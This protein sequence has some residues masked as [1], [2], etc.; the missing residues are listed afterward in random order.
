VKPD[1]QVS[2]SPWT[3]AWDRREILRLGA[4]LAAGG[5]LAPLIS[6]CGTSSQAATPS[7]APDASSA[8]ASLAGPITVL[9][10]VEFTTEQG[11][12]KV[13]DDFKAQNPAIEW[14]IR[15]LSGG[16]PEWDRLARASITSGE[17]VGFVVINGQQVRGWVRDGLLADLGALPEMAD[18]LARVPAKYHLSGPGE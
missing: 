3:R 4:F 7:G 6:A 5:A 13:Y 16:G 17:P 14:D 12:M 18:V 9:M 1:P 11:L 2:A 15:G 10:P 8:T